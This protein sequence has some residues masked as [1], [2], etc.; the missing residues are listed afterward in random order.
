MTI[1]D[2]IKTYLQDEAQT[3]ATKLADYLME[4]GLTPKMEWSHGFRFVKNDKSPCL[5]FF[6]VSDNA[7]GEWVLCDL[8]VVNEPEWQ[9]LGDDHKAFILAHLKVCGI[10]DGS[11]PCGCGSEPG[12]TKVIFGKSYDNICTSE[13]QLPNPDEGMLDTFKQLIDWWVVQIGGA[14]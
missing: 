13:I 2:A 11:H 7:A 5:L 8:P 3:R 10:H 12:A 14:E 1:H 9:T 6:I 4:I